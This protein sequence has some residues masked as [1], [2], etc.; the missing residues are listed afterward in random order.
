MVLNS[1]VVVLR[2]WVEVWQRKKRQFLCHEQ[3]GAAPQH[4][5]SDCR[6]AEDDLRQ[7]HCTNR[8]HQ[9]LLEVS[10]ETS[11]LTVIA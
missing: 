2:R 7:T 1:H 3:E 9:V 4:L 5:A 6:G 11:T 8:Q 10:L